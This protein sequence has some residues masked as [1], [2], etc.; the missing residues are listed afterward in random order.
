MTDP[1]KKA[2]SPT[3]AQVDAAIAKRR[4]DEAA[5]KRNAA[6]VKRRATA[7]EALTARTLKSGSKPSADEI[8]DLEFATQSVQ[9]RG[10]L[11][12]ILH[13]QFNKLATQVARGDDPD[14]VAELAA[15]IVTR[16]RF[17][18]AGI[19]ETDSPAAAAS[20]VKDPGSV[21]WG[22]S[23]PPVNEAI[24]TM[25]SE[26]M[27]AAQNGAPLAAGDLKPDRDLT[28]EQ[29]AAWTDEVTRLSKRITREWQSGD[30]GRAQQLA[31]RDGSDLAGGL[32]VERK[33]RPEDG[34]TDPAQLAALIPRS[35]GPR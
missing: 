29:A 34:I 21:G 30:H 26:L 22:Y 4:E 6:A 24:R 20:V 35:G 18:V 27:F 12:K 33:S 1:R 16:H 32:A 9:R 13:N 23:R 8:R 25:R 2:A 3:E 11:R 19:T 7:F 10:E 17:E 14:D 31:E 28:P 5:S 15:E